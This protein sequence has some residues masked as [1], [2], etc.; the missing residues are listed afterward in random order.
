MRTGALSDAFDRRERSRRHVAA[1]VIS[2]GANIAFVVALVLLMR[3]LEHAAPHAVARSDGALEVR[4][5]ESRADTSSATIDS[6]TVPP[7]STPPTLPAPTP[8][9]PIRA[10]VQRVSRETAPI[11]VAEAPIEHPPM[12]FNADGS[13]RLAPAATDAT[14]ASADMPA[15][16]RMPADNPLAR[17]LPSSGRPSRFEHAW[18]APEGETLAGEVGRRTTVSGS[19]RTP[20]G[21]QISCSWSLIVGGCG[22][23]RPPHVTIEELKR[24][25]ADP[26]PPKQ[27][28]SPDL[29][30]D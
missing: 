2:L 15:R 19:W 9:R 20:W 5:I 29:P 25:R 8:T 30:S 16:P 7:Q 11:T 18:A 6:E 4:L 14:S 13:V 22:W 21:T 24:M 3:P 17:T 26:P 12:L 1:L 23:G 27:S 28:A 10:P